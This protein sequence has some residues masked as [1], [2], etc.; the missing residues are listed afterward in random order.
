[1]NAPEW[2]VSYATGYAILLAKKHRAKVTIFSAVQTDRELEKEK[3]Y[4]ARLAEMC[5]THGVPFEEHF[6]KV[7]NIVD[8]VVAEAAGHD[9]LV[10]G[11]SSEWR[12]TQFAFGPM[13]D[14]IARRAGMPTLMVRKVRRQEQWKPPPTPPLPA[15]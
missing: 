1:M 3:A 6:L 14:Q 9:L 11:A 8:A 15:A 12:L 10:L 4:S 7:R 13:Q 5:R 2:H